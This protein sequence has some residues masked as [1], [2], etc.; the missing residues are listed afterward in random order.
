MVQE[1]IKGKLTLGKVGIATLGRRAYTNEPHDPPRRHIH[2]LEEMLHHHPSIRQCQCNPFM[3]WM[4]NDECPTRGGR[5]DW[6]RTCDQRVTDGT[7]RFR[8]SCIC[9]WRR[10]TSRRGTSLTEHA[11]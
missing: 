6:W 9:H 4:R 1:S 3:Q 2:I 10:G 5:A 8:W 11:H 7:P